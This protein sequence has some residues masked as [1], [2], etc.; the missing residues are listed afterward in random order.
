MPERPP[1]RARRLRIE[2]PGELR[3]TPG[4]APQNSVVPVVH[5]NL[6]PAARENVRPPAHREAR[7]GTQ[8]QPPADATAE[9]AFVTAVMRAEVAAAEFPED[10]RVV[11][12]KEQEEG[13]RPELSFPTPRVLR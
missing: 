7:V 3:E 8:T 6:V 2:H 13:V 9:V 1:H 10:S 11:A 5:R 4:H 12:C